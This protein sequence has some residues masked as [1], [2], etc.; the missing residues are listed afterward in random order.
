MGLPLRCRKG[1]LLMLFA[2]SRREPYALRLCEQHVN[3]VTKA[4]PVA[5]LRVV[6]RYPAASAL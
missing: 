6:G 4:L 5:G 2:G 3:Q 1:H